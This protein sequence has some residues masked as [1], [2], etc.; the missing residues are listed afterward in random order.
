MVARGEKTVVTAVAN[1]SPAEEAGVSPGDELVALDGLRVPAGGLDTMLR[2]YRVRD[3][4]RLAVFRGDELL[5]L[6]LTFAPAP[7]NT[8]YLELAGDAGDEAV[9][10]RQR[11]LGK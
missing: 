2:R 8:V 11:F 7:E 6:D 4:V 5:T 10:L 3:A 9:A 1:E